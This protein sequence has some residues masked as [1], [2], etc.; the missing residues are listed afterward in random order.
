MLAILLRCFPPS[1]NCEPNMDTLQK[2]W[3]GVVWYL[4]FNPNLSNFQA[5]QQ[6]SLFWRTSQGVA[7]TACL[8]ALQSWVHTE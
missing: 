2:L 4:A 5:L 8:Q 3:Q 7:G 1:W 6:R